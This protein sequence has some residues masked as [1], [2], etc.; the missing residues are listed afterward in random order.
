MTSYR[1]TLTYTVDVVDEGAL[2]RAGAVAWAASAGGW[3]V[4]VDDDGAVTE[5]AAGEAPE[6]PGP[7]AS[8][9][10]LIGAQPHPVLS[11]VRFT[12]SSVGVEQ[13]APE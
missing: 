3:A 7:D 2:L 5:V 12:A 9:A 10:F 1:V 11:G 4:R 8:L 13:V 6:S